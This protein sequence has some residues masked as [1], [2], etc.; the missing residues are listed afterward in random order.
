MK[1]IH[2]LEAPKA[3]GPYSHGV[4]KNGIFFSSGQ[5]GINSVRNELP[6]SFSEQAEQVMCNLGSILKAA[7]LTFSNV[8]KVTVY[9]KDLNNFDQFQEIYK[10]YFVEPY[11]ARDT[12]EVSRLP[13]NAAIEISLIAIS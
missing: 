6:E 8:M 11:P 3:L 4:M 13:K 12:I 10:K 1:S 7:D 9:L 2:A 5:I